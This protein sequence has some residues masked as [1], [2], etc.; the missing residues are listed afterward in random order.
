LTGGPPINGAQPLVRPNGTVVVAFTA[1]A[2]YPAVGGHSIAVARSTDGGR[3][4]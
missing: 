4:G 1:L 3:S 2:G